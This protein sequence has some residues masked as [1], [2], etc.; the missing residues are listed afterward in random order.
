[1]TDEDRKKIV[2]AFFK[3]WEQGDSVAIRK[4]YAEYLSDDCVYENSGLAPMVGKEAILKFVDIGASSVGVATMEV[5]T[6]GWGFGPNTVYSERVDY[7]RDSNGKLTLVPLIC[8]VMVFNDAGKIIRWSDYYDPA[9]MLAQ[10]KGS[11]ALAP[12]LT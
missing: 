8:G 6:K 2:E 11:V 12:D 10:L 7:H 3:A 9:P 4:A 1:M 5:E